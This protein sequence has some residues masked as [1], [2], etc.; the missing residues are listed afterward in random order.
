MSRWSLAT[1]IVASFLAYGGTPLV[2]Q[3]YSAV[4]CASMQS[5]SG[6]GAAGLLDRLERG[7]VQYTQSGC[8]A[9]YTCPSGQQITCM[10]ATSCSVTSVS[11]SAQG[12]TCPDQGGSVGAIVC[13]GAVQ[14]ACPCPEVCFGCGSSCT[15][16]AD[17]TAACT[18]GSGFCSQGKCTCPY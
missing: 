17:C 13:N 7:G 14:Q 11:C 16:R 6:A 10:G 5:P 15:T 2:T 4:L 8:T 18:C 1:A 9:H 12:S 3:E